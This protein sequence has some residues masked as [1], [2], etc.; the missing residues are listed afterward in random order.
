MSKAFTRESDNE[1]ELP[2][3]SRSPSTLPPGVK[4]Y[5]TTKGFKDLQTRLAEL[6]LQPVTPLMQQRLFELREQLQSAVVV[7]RPPL[8]WRQVL[9]GATVK[10]ENQSGETAAY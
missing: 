3:A 10:V 2:A 4:N 6:E 9:F 8:P 7:E 5:I 1:T